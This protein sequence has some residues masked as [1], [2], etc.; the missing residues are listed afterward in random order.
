MVAPTTANGTGSSMKKLNWGKHT[1]SNSRAADQPW[2]GG[3]RYWSEFNDED[4]EPYTIVIHHGSGSESGEPVGFLAKLSE[5]L[6]RVFNAEDKCEPEERRPLLPDPI[7]SYA[8]SDEEGSTRARTRAW[9]EAQ[10][11]TI[12]VQRK[13]DALRE[14]MIF[15]GYCLSFAVSIMVLSVTGGWAFTHK[16]SKHGPAFRTGLAETVGVFAAAVFA[17]YA[18]SLFIA[19]KERVGTLHKVVVMGLF[20]GICLMGSVVLS[21]VYNNWLRP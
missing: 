3:E 11:N 12:A 1:K 19:R 8:S 4:D 2:L 21:V 9:T 15:R 5:S 7:C 16:P 14:K 13:K 17:G 20:C 6:K 10:D 18:V